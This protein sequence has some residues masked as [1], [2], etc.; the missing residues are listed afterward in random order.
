MHRK[1]WPYCGDCDVD[2]AAI[3][4]GGGN[5]FADIVGTDHRCLVATR[6]GAIAADNPE[7]IACPDTS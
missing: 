1:R 2:I 4:T 3:C 7:S 6:I 5:D